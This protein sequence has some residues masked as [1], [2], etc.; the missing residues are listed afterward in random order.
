MSLPASLDLATL[1]AAY[2][3]G[4][5]TP[6]EV[7]SSIYDRI[8]AEGLAPVW[9]S[10]F[11]KEAA[12]SRLEQ[13]PR[14]PLWGIPCAVKDN[15]DVAGLA[16]T[17]ACPAFA[18][19]PARS[20]T[21]VERLEAAGAVVIGKTNL[22][23]FA[24]GLVG[25]RTPYGICANVFN[26]SYIS[27]GS[28]SGS[29][30]AVASGLV[31]FAL[32]TDTA[33]SGR[34]PAG[35][36]NIV[37]LKPTKGL[38]STRGLVPACRSQDVISIFAATV[39]D[40]VDV[41]TVAEGFDA[42]DA[43]SRKA[44]AAQPTLPAIQGLRFGVPATLDFF[45]DDDAAKLYAATVDRMEQLGGVAV[46]IDYGPFKE[47]AALLYAGPFVAE[48]LAAVKE[49]AGRAPDAFDP[50]VGGIIK[51]AAGISSVATFEGLYRL[52]ELTRAAET[53]WAKIDVMLLPTSGT[54][55][56]IS[57][58]LADPVRL[59]TNLGAYTN[60]VNLMDLAALAVPAGFRPNGL[61]FGVTLVGRAFTDRSLGVIGDALYRALPGASLAATGLPLPSEAPLAAP[62]TIKPSSPI[63]VAVVGAHLSGQP[64]NAQLTERN[65]V[66]L[67]TTRTAGG[68]R[69]VALPGTMPP[70]PG[71][72]ADRNAAGGIEVELW[73]LDPAGFGSF[74]SLIPPPLCIGTLRLADGRLV[75]G[76]LCEAE[77]AEGAEYITHHS[78]WRAYLHAMQKAHT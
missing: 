23:Q 72:I 2:A 53:L 17:C 51:A 38:L 14:G 64:L 70:K 4:S 5:T 55:Y 52:A 54:I 74:V 39:G 48:R 77:A 43:Y 66:F 12:L 44:P 46:T 3:S 33:G 41:L 67:E 24:T 31:S 61:P 18:Y 30:V 27:G 65:A 6:A 36:N 58:V 10:V 40:A 37:G 59:N 13:A 75:K 50:V 15:I 73:Q 7:I 69:F 26:G 16:T 25:T 76:F 35:F 68:Y 9:I 49:F 56:K 62:A 34:V 45:G 11:A 29:A 32:G 21:V 71:L 22:D 8:D 1:R 47:A 20:A 78:G 19:E 28:S 42:D 63:T 60:F 57:D